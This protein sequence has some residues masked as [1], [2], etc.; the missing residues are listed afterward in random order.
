MKSILLTFAAGLL[1]SAGSLHAQ[2]I[3][4]SQ[5]PSVI[6]NK[7]AT[8]Y[9]KAKDIDWERKG[10]LYNVEFELGRN[11]DH[12]IWYDSKGVIVRH[13]EDIA[14]SSL[15]AAVTSKL[16]KDF[17]GYRIDDPEKITEGGKVTYKLELKSF[18]K[19]WDI[20]IDSQ[21]NILKQKED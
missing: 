7:F 19:D 14:K 1:F 5:V 8:Q 17:K 2:D 15:P 12:E 4:T 21:G 13:K 18:T 20:V 11:I 6:A 9:P 16:A 10:E 3:P